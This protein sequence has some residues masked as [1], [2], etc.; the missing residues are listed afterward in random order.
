MSL[1]KLLNFFDSDT[2]QLFEFELGS[3]VRSR[4]LNAAPSNHLAGRRRKRQWNNGGFSGT[5][6]QVNRSHGVLSSRGRAVAMLILLAGPAGT[7]LLAPHFPIDRPLLRRLADKRFGGIRPGRAENRLGG[8]RNG[9][10][11]ARGGQSGGCT[12]GRGKRVER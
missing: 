2:P 3:R 6:M 9:G 4:P 8:S 12:G 11:G 5:L 1:K 7:S 10:G